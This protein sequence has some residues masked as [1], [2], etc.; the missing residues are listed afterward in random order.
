MDAPP[1]PALSPRSARRLWRCA[2]GLALALVGAGCGGNENPLAPYEGGRALT[3]LQVTQNVTPDV[4]WVGGRVAAVG[5]NHGPRA[6]LDSTLVWMRLSSDAADSIPS[7]ATV[8]EGTTAG[9]V[10]GYGG[11]P[12]EHLAH[13]ETYTFWIAEASALAAGLDPVDAG[14]F[15]DTTVT[16]QL[17]LRGQPDSDDPPGGDPA[18]SVRFEVERSERLTGERFIV[19]WTPATVRFRHLAIRR[20]SIGGFDNLV[21]YVHALDGG[22]AVIAPPFTTGDIPAGVEEV[23]TFSGF[24]R[25]VY[26]LWA[27][28]DDWT[29]S[30]APSARGY[31]WFRLLDTNFPEG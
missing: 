16:L 11:T 31:T 10:E 3:F 21:W 6:A 9:A 18:L 13:G 4:Q 1:T 2:V 15:A 27:A 26:F 20:A 28:T 24:S 23:T 17:L 25:N 30:F 14:A 22:P 7:Y 5:V 29:G 19:R 12:L 8:G